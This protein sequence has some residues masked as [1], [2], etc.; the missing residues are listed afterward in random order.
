MVLGIKWS[1]HGNCNMCVEPCDSCISDCDGIGFRINESASD[2]EGDA[3]RG[4]D[5]YSLSLS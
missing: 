5:E 3:E 1:V 2:S 4:K